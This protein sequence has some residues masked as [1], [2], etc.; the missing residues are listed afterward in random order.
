MHNLVSFMHTLVSLNSLSCISHLCLFFCLDESPKVTS[1]PKRLS[2]VI[3][4]TTASFTVQATGTDPL[5]YEWQWK[6]AEEKSG[7][8]EW[9]P[10]N[11]SWSNGATLTIPSVQKS[12]EGWYHCVISNCAGRVIS[13]PIQLSV[14]KSKKIGFS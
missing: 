8:K 3:Q 6:P 10:C 14:G 5:N 1:Q 9:Q 7:R 13:K 12:N 4:G 11:T 2:K